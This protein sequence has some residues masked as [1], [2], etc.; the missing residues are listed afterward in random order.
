MGRFVNWFVNSK[1]FFYS[2]VLFLLDLNMQSIFS[3]ALLMDIKGNALWRNVTCLPQTSLLPVFF[4]QARWDEISPPSSGSALVSPPSWACLE[5]RGTQEAS[6]SDA[7]TTS[8][9]PFKYTGAAALLRGPFGCPNINFKAEPSYPAIHFTC[10]Y[11][12]SHSFCNYTQLLSMGQGW[13]LDG[14]VDQ[15]FAAQPSVLLKLHQTTCPSHTFT[16]EKDPELLKLLCLGQELITQPEVTISCFQTENHGLRLRGFL[17][18]FPTTSHSQVQTAPVHLPK[19]MGRRGQQNH[20]ICKKQRPNYQVN[21]NP[22][23]TR[24]LFDIVPS[25]QTQLPLWS[26]KDWIGRNNSPSTP[27][28][29]S[30]PC[31][32]PT[33]TQS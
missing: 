18:F 25:K 1:D 29:H 26:H 22:I 2:T 11:P 8:A 3:F 7:R 33:G 14:L 9:G 10:Y 15:S 30:T 12:Q 5:K 6:R 19:V 28:S 27:Y 13:N 17:T 32:T 24:K 21:P 23:P 31:S 16:R 4:A 20:I